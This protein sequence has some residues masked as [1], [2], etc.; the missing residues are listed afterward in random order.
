MLGIA[1]L[2]YI[3]GPTKFASSISAST[4]A[5]HFDIDNNSLIVDFI[6]KA[7]YFVQSELQTLD[8]DKGLS[9]EV[10]RSGN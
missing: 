4:H 7:I 2:C 3:F 10:Q 9:G 6:P 5:P 1:N 8:T